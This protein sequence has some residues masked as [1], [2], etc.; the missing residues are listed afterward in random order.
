MKCLRVSVSSQPADLHLHSQQ[1]RGGN[2]SDAYRA[3]SACGHAHIPEVE[4]SFIDDD[5]DDELEAKPTDS[6][7]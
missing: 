3:L 1:R 5:D 6:D 2:D 7:V 4:L